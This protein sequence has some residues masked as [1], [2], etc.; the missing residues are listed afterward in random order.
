MREFARITPR[1]TQRKKQAQKK[2]TTG[3]IDSPAR[4]P[5]C[6]RSDK[7]ATPLSLALSRLL[8]LASALSPCV[9]RTPYYH[10]DTRTCRGTLLS[11]SHTPHHQELP[12]QQDNRLVV[13]NSVQIQG[14]LPQARTH[15]HIPK[16]CSL[17]R[18]TNER[19]KE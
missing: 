19:R 8:A 7:H 13:T 6:A 11:Q 4:S 15:R 5:P 12:R 10:P 17:D 2:E 16:A 14:R 18:N 3:S 9:R 1:I